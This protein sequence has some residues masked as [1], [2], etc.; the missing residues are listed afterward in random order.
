[1]NQFLNKI[2]DC[3]LPDDQYYKDVYNKRQIVIHHTVSN[4]NAKNVINWWKKQV[5]K[6]GTAF[7]IDRE[8]VIHKAFS[9]AHWAH[10]LGTKE[11]NNRILNKQSIGI[12]LCCWGSLKFKNEKYLST[13]GF[14][15]H[16]DEVT[17]YEHPFRGVNYFQKYT[18]KQLESLKLLLQYL[19]ET[20]KIPKTYIPEMWEYSKAAV[21]GDK[22]IFTHVPIERI[23]A[24]AIHKKS[25]WRC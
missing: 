22:G 10:H 6:I 1:M 25:W 9:S 3:P 12:E 21:K 20:Y 13:T 17:T 5:E 24:I 7:V 2:I 19:C 16:K 23:K 8:G 14:E 11:K 4:G 18:E 15:I